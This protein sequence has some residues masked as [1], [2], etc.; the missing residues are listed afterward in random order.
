MPKCFLE[1]SHEEPPLGGT[2]VG[3]TGVEEG[4][5][6]E[7]CQWKRCFQDG[8]HGR[9]RKGAKFQAGTY[10]SKFKLMKSEREERG[11]GEGENGAE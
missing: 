1:G 5:G 10:S 8:A 6:R 9:R 7:Q 11:G 3:R 4:R 2:D